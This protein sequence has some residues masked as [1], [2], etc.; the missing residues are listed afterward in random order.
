MM[1]QKG[2][3]SSNWYQA[4]T[5]AERI[6]S[7]HAIDD[8]SAAGFGGNSDLATRRMNEWRAQPPFAVHSRFSQRLALDEISEGEFLR[9]LGEPA[10]SVQN[11]FSLPPRW[12]EELAIAFS[13]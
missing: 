13:T 2:I 5:L 10:E 3:H 7:L 4:I 9:L 6:T 8:A 12:L 1:D 11:R